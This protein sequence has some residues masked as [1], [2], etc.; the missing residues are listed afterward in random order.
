VPSQ[1]RWVQPNQVYETTLRTV[2]RQFSFKPNQHS[3]N[4]LLAESSP[5]NALDPNND[6]IPEPSILNI[7]GAAVGR[8]LE[9]YPVQLHSFESNI[10]HLHEVFSVTEEQRDNL[11]G[12]LRTVHSLIA[13]G[14]NKTWVGMGISSAG[15]PEFTRGR[16]GDGPDICTS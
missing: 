3:K 5:L 4:P 14:V 15:G 8:A 9:Q 1:I 2:D 11:P 16:L 10:S 7:I 12:F 13:R 6:I